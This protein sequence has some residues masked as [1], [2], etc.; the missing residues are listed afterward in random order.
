M[1]PAYGKMDAVKIDLKSFTESYYQKVV[2]GQLKPVLETLVTLRKMGKWMEIVY[3]V[4]PTLNDSD[5]EFRGLAQWVKANLG[6]GCAAAF[7]AVSS[8]I[9]AEES[10]H[11]AGAYS[12]TRQGDCRC[13][14]AALRLYRQCAWTS[15]AKH[16]LPASASKMLVERVGIHGQPDADSEGQCPFCQHPIPGIWHV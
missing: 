16:I 1:K 3:L 8:R 7:H 10:A 14:G 9:S 5:Q 12:G 15:G 6:V 13:R 4:V 11:H 2:T